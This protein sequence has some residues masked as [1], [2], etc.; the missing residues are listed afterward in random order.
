ME[1]SPMTVIV[2]LRLLHVV[3]TG[4][5]ESKNQ[6]CLSTMNRTTPETANSPRI[7]PH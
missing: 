1:N 3:C 2:V 6:V 5:L 7:F 4:A